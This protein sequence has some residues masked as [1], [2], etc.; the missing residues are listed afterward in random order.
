MDWAG[1]LINVLAII[2]GLAIY[3]GIMNSKFGKSHVQWQYAIMLVAIILACF[4][5]GFLRVI[6]GYL[7]GVP[8]HV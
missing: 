3:V 7:L 1:M 8:V 6:F 4:I 2:C 5:G